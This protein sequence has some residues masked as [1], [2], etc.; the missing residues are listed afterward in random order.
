M[1][2]GTSS[3]ND[4][5]YK[6]DYFSTN[7]YSNYTKSWGGHNFS[8]LAGFNAELKKYNTDS[9]YGESLI[10][11]SPYLS[12]TQRNFSVGGNANDLF[13]GRFLRTY[14]LQLQ[15]TLPFGTERTLRRFFTLRERQTLGILPIHVHRLEH[16]Q[17]GLLPELD[18]DIPDPKPR[19]SNWGQL[20]NQNTSNWYPF[21]QT[22]ST[23]S[24]EW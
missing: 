3:V 23:G 8:V 5:T 6:Q 13:S 17:R 10:S 12:Q 7:I 11:P 2:T 15:G 9:G 21:Y 18:Q 4:Y 19:F 24:A 16:R 14:Q 22:M 20:G 1:A